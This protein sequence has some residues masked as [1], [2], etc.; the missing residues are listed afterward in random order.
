MGHEELELDQAG[1]FSLDCKLT[2]IPVSTLLGC[3][4]GWHSLVPL[5]A[6][7][8]IILNNQE[9]SI[10]QASVTIYQD[11]FPNTFEIPVI[12]SVSAPSVLRRY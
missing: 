2:D 3:S 6:E 5:P 7:V 10:H 1:G 4:K 9:Q 11:V 8:S 12:A